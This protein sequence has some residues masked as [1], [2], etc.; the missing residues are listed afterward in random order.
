[1]LRKSK[2]LMKE[3]SKLW[4]KRRKMLRRKWFVLRN[5]SNKKGGVLMSEV[6]GKG[7]KD[8]GHKSWRKKE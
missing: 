7:K 6:R 3:H 2:I 8:K 4:K 5:G 1:M